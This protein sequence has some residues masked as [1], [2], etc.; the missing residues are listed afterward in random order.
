MMSP[1]REDFGERLVRIE[2][3]VDA[4][5]DKL[6]EANRLADIQRARLEHSVETLELKVDRSIGTVS[7]RV[8]EIE[9]RFN[10]LTGILIAINFAAVFFADKIRA[11][12][13]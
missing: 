6:L 1:E 7:Q 5:I 9:R 3:K 2:T 11:V 8:T 10:I 4:L 13:H 12:F